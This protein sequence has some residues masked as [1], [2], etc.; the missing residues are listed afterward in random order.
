[1]ASTR[2]GVKPLSAALGFL[3]VFLVFGC[4][5][6]HQGGLLNELF[7]LFVLVVGIA[8]FQTDRRAWLLLVWW[9]WVLAPE[10]RRLSDWQAG[11]HA[12]SPI[13]LAPLLVSMVCVPTLINELRTFASGWRRGW[14][15]IAA[16]ITAGTM[17][18]IVRAGPFSAIYSSLQWF[19]PVLVAAYITLEWR[20]YPQLARTMLRMAVMTVIV[21]GG[22]CLYQYF[23]YPPWDQFWARNSGLAELTNVTAGHFRPYSTLNAPGNLAFITMA[24]VIL[25]F[26]YRGFLRPVAIAVG[27]MVLTISRVRSTWALTLIALGALVL[28]QRRNASRSLRVIIILAA[29]VGGLALQSGTVGSLVS[30]RISQTT[31]GSSDVSLTSR[32]DFYKATAPSALLDP[33]GKGIGSTGTAT[34]LQSGSNKLGT[35]A[36]FDSGVLDI[37]YELGWIGSLLL[38]GGVFLLSKQT[39]RAPPDDPFVLGARCVAIAAV[40]FLIFSSDL[41]SNVGFFI[42]L[43]LGVVL[44]GSRHQANLAESYVA[45]TE[46]STRLS[47]G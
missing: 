21:V 29:A 19:M 25:G 30:Q 15:L 31:T 46:R 41:T 6:V 28:M 3:L 18:G 5:V 22:Y 17:V 24:L 43:P 40:L 38:L 37:P 42:W 13:Q 7:P 8:L 35:S 44:A 16:G 32:I 20:S 45:E 4:L 36:V 33:P 11:F 34:R 39:M 14:L 1:M 2:D 23:V 27:G 26:Q 47:P 12:T 9:M 10:V